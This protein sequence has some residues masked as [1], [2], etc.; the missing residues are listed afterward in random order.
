MVRKPGGWSLE[1]SASTDERKTF[2][3]EIEAEF[4]R[5]RASAYSREATLTLNYRPSPNLL[6]SVAPYYSTSHEETQYV[7]TLADPDATSTFNHRYI[8]AQL[9]QRV[10]ELSTRFDWTLN[11]RLS[12]QLYVQPFIASGDYHD[13]TA[14]VRARS[15]DYAP[16]AGPV[17][18]LDF[19]LR[20]VRGSA[21]ARWEFRRGSA[22]YVVWNENRADVVNEGD[23]RFGRDLRAIPNAPSHDVLL[24]KLSY[25]LPL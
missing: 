17:P 18:D 1:T 6:L 25:W 12:F 13:P 7:T 9:E 2:F 15:A 21:V 8:F 3:A 16:Y 10:F 20:S 11:P 4:N 22:L 24:V 19:N 23:F 5:D 14:L